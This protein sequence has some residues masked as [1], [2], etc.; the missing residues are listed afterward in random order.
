[1]DNLSNNSYYQ[2]IYKRN[3]FE[4]NLYFTWHNCK[5]QIQYKIHISLVYKNIKLT[6]IQKIKKFNLKIVVHF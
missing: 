6:I 2:Y 1:M 4:V 5:I 3:V